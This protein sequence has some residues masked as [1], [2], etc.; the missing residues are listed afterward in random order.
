MTI[1]NCVLTLALCVAATTINAQT[2]QLRE[3]M[4][5]KK[6]ANGLTVLVIED[7]SVPLATINLTFK[8]GAFTESPAFSGVAAVYH[9]MLLKGNK[10]YG[11]SDQANYRTSQMAMMKGVNVSEERALCNITMPSPL[12]DEGLRYMNSAIRYPVLDEQEMEKGRSVADRELQTKESNAL[13]LLNR[14]MGQHLWGNLSNRKI[15]IGSHESLKGVSLALIDSVRS[16]YYYP[17]NAL[18]TV[19]GRVEHDKV[20]TKVEELYGNWQPLAADPFKKWP[21]PPFKPITRTDYFTVESTTADV[22]FILL[23]WQ[24]PSAKTDVASTYAADV[25]SYILTQNS[26]KLN[27]ALVQSGLALQIDFNY[28]TLSQGGPITFIIKPNLQKIKECLAEVKKQIALFD[29]DD[30][31]TTEQI[32]TAQRKLEITKVR[33]E[34]VTSEFVNTLSFWWSSA[35]LNYFFTYIDNL[36]KVKKA[37]LQAYVRRYIKNKAYCAGLL[38]NPTLRAQLKA[39]EFFKATN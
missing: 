26:S 19:A 9:N 8:N 14:T 21:V 27:K 3:N 12:V 32:A 5:S 20:F 37:N 6:L 34:E 33:Q 24:G 10:D 17:D 22:P 36:Q 39:D 11:N 7:N 29:T 23:S 15:A 18:L 16:K 31:V 38:I 35:S 2:Q 28:L 13:F 25:F 4:F 30:Y 1:K